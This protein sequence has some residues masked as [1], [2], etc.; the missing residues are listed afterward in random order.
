M[1][2]LFP[3]YFADDEDEIKSLWKDCLFVFDANVLIN[4]YKY[5]DAA[6]GE[7]LQV[8]ENQKQRIWL[9]NRVAEEFLTNRVKV[10]VEQSNEYTKALKDI[11]KLQESFDNK[12]M[13]PHVSE[14][15]KLQM[16]E[17]FG[18][19]N[20]ELIESK[21][22][23]K[24][25][26]KNDHIKNKLSMLLEGRVGHPFLKD[27]LI[28]I[29]EEGEARYLENIPP[30]YEDAHKANSK[31]G[32]PS[33]S[34][35]CRIYGDYIIWLQ[36]LREA[37]SC[38]KNI[39]FVTDDAKK[40]WWE[41]YDRTTVG[42]RP[43]LI[44]EFFNE[45]NKHF[46]MYKSDQFMQLAKEYLN[47]TITEGTLVE[48]QELLLREEKE[49]LRERFATINLRANQIEQRFQ[50]CVDQSN[51]LNEL[52]GIKMGEISDL[53]KIGNNSIIVEQLE[54]DIS[55]LKNDKEL[56][57]HEIEDLKE[58]MQTDMFRQ[59]KQIQREIY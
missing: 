43:E 47:E 2:S 48:I 22:I 15:M 31:E 49:V 36:I 56:I 33:F 20:D 39:I 9:A 29:F 1:K 58:L 25:R 57:D 54:R 14:K 50:E 41:Q 19:L 6:T 4:L 16:K 17:F 42:P 38:D 35:K 51:T 34:D 13:H 18:L 28:K 40:D 30:G 27:D 32:V 45:T 23:Q 5:S 11:S 24:K 26:L 10:L 8:L 7:F 59:M 55:N 44:E 46:Y 3:G 12:R 53:R 37:R 21:R 52:L